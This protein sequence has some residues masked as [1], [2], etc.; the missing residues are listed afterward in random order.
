MCCV[1][2]KCRPVAYELILERFKVF[3]AILNDAS[4]I[5]DASPSLSVLVKIVVSLL[6]GKDM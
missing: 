3:F 1:I 2:Y 6:L 5:T 4:I